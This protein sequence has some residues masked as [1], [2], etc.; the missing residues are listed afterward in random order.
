[1]YLNFVTQVTNDILTRGVFSDRVLQQVFE[2]HIARQRGNL[3]EVQMRALLDTLRD[4][5]GIPA[6]QSSDFHQKVGDI[7]PSSTL[8][9]STTSERSHF[10]KQMD[11]EA[12]KSYV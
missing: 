5:L 4:D 3:D 12:G 1:M 6:R 8:S 7:V 9:A 2:E 10:A 11:I